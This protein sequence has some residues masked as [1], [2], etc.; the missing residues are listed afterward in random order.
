MN[1]GLSDSM[2]V[3]FYLAKKKVRK[4]NLGLKCS[5]QLFFFSALVI[6]AFYF[7]RGF[8]EEKEESQT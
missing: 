2:H 1:Q 4:L 7:S 3:L 8:I 6:A 5:S